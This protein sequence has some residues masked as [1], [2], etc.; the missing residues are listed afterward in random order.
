MIIISRS[1]VVIISL[2]FLYIK[3]LLCYTLFVSSKHFIFPAF[4]FSRMFS[5]TNGLATISFF[6]SKR[7][8]FP[9]R[10]WLSIWREHSRSRISNG[11]FGIITWK[12]R[13][14]EKT[15]NILKQTIQ[16]QAET[17]QRLEEE[18]NG[19]GSEI[20]PPKKERSRGRQVD[21][22]SQLQKK[23]EKSWIDFSSNSLPFRSCVSVR[24]SNGCRISSSVLDSEHL[25]SFYF[26]AI[27]GFLRAVFRTKE[28][29]RSTK[30]R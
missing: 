7:S 28:L 14:I 6:Q 26:S 29:K 17:I 9:W 23:K 13:H 22:N 27:G 20:G 8:D 10:R 21:P 5:P 19:L 2:Y 25:S 30:W 15:V 3:R 1:A 4:Y 24:E 16:T 12:S 11:E 18:R